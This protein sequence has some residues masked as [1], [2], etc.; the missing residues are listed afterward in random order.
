LRKQF[1]GWLF[2]TYAGIYIRECNDFDRKKQI[3][4]GRFCDMDA[5]HAQVEFEESIVVSCKY[6]TTMAAA[7]QHPWKRK[8]WPARSK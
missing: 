1:N 8:Q 2:A 3:F 4:N 7:D 6:L 5:N